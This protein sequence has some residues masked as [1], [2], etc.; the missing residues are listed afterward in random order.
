MKDRRFWANHLLDG[1]NDRNVGMIVLLQELKVESI[2]DLT[3]KDAC[4]L[5]KSLLCVLISFFLVTLNLFFNMFKHLC[6]V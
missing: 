3:L 5:S 4:D 1:V 2:S 6:L